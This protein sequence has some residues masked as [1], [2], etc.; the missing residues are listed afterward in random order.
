MAYVSPKLVEEINLQIQEA[1]KTTT[2]RKMKKAMLGQRA[3]KFL[4]NKEEWEK[5]NITWKKKWRFTDREIAIIAAFQEKWWRLKG[6]GQY[7]KRL[8][9]KAF[10]P[11]ILYSAKA[12]FKNKCET[13]T[14]SDKSKQ[15]ISIGKYA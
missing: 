15:R 2:L 8:K 12:F 14:F 9:G 6:V 3:F 1:Q 13:K 11:R 7:L 4:K 5:L 10:Q